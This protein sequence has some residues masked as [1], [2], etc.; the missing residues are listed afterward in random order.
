M[1]T[2]NILQK[3]IPSIINVACTLVLA[4]P[5][6]LSKLTARRKKLI[7]IAL[8]FLFNLF[9]LIFFKFRDLGMMA[10]G[11]Y[12]KEDYSLWQQLVYTALYTASFSTL[13]YKIKYPF[14]LFIIN[15]L[16]LQLPCILLTG[17]TLHG[18][19]SGSMTTIISMA[20][21]IK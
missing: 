19:L 1:Q 6:L 7:L 10:M 15:M 17:T 4:S 16:C 5:F 14:D 2:T 20:T 12:W 3:L 11:T 8:F 18:F 9:F 21:I 13:L